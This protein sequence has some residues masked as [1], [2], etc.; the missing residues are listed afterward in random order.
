MSITTNNGLARRQAAPT[1][2]KVVIPITLRPSQ[3]VSRPPE[4]NDRHPVLIWDNCCC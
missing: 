1:P 3:V 4:P 2:L